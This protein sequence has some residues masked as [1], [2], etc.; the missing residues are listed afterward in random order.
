MSLSAVLALS[1]IPATAQGWS[2]ASSNQA[3]AASCNIAPGSARDT[4]HFFSGCTRSMRNG[5]RQRAND[6]ARLAPY[7]ASVRAQI[8]EAMSRNDVAFIAP[9][10]TRRGSAGLARFESDLAAGRDSDTRLAEVNRLGEPYSGMG[11]TGLAYFILQFSRLAEQA[12]YRGH[13]DDAALYRA[14][15]EA[16]LRTV[17]TDGRQG[18]LATVSNCRGSGRSCAFFHSVTRKDRP[19]DFGATLN[20]KLHVLRDLGLISELYRRNGWRE[21]FDMDR[22][23]AE[24]LNQLFAQGPRQRV[25]DEPSFAD[26]LAP[27]VGRDRVQWLYYGYNAERAPGE[28]GYFLPRAGKNC[29]YQVHSLGLI[30]RILEDAQKTRRWPVREALSCDGALAKAYRATRVRLTVKQKSRWSDGSTRFNTVCEPDEATKFAAMQR[31][32]YNQA[33]AGCGR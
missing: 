16:M 33:F 5:W 18:G 4:W 11:Q 32:F 12:S 28:G 24:G 30:A 2:S 31:D 13:E 22:A 27:P 21:P 7:A 20:Q 23:I 26:Y 1:L 8:V 15:G 25:G 19:A 17:V 3:R 14:L 10:G 6:P 9:G 29:N